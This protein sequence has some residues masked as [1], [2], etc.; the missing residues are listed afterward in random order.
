MVPATPAPAASPATSADDFALDF[1]LSSISLDLDSPAGAP[2]PA[3]GSAPEPGA[4]DTGEID[5]F[6]PAGAAEPVQRKLDLAEEL[7]QLGDSNGA[8]DLLNEI[9]GQAEGGQKTRAEALLAQLP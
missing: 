2:L 5:F 6:A 9:L 7:L 8:R 3:P 1:D 4:L